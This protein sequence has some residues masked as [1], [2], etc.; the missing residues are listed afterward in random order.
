MTCYLLHIMED[1]DRDAYR[2][3]DLKDVVGLV[4][5]FFCAQSQPLVPLT[6]SEAV[7]CIRRNAPCWK[8]G[9]PHTPAAPSSEG[10]AGPH[11]F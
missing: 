11:S 7:K 4:P 6:L 8:T 10:I 3:P 5:K 9:E 2:D 1:P